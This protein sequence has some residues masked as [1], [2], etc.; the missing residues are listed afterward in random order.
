MMRLP[1]FRY[2]APGTLEEAA[3]IMAGEGPS[4]SLLAGGTDLL[5]KLK[6]G[7]QEPAAL[8]SLSKIG[9]LREMR[10][11]KGLTLG[12]GVSL[13]EIVAVPAIC[14]NY[15][16]LWQA[17]SQVA[18]PQI[19]NVGT[20]GGNLCVD[21]R[22]TYHDQSHDWRK[23]I[24]FCI[25]QD[26][27]TCWASPTS[28]RCWAVSSSD[29]APALTALGAEIR[30]V[31][32]GGE[33]ILPL[34]DFYCDDGAA[35]LTRRPDEILAE[36]ILPPGKG[37][38]STYWKLRRRGAYDFP[39]ASVAAAVATDGDGTVTAARLYLGAIVSG[40]IACRDAESL[41]VGSK[42]TDELIDEASK[43]AGATA[44][45]KENTDAP[46]YWR[47]RMVVPM[48][49]WALKELRGDDMRDQ[50]RRLAGQPTA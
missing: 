24:G 13:G 38:K 3:G 34:E 1:Q 5:P 21:T 15:R 27:E 37:W 31:S 6:R 16:A 44:R 43:L 39:I 29:T 17:A 19:R 12:A 4:A 26:G 20:V 2:F 48:T 42:L 18:T 11:G 8:V 49:T 9:H 28:D 50:R 40:F 36:I 41:L 35:H 10:N 45:P 30:L 14:E 25:K 22:C 32:A 23:A 7:Q 46:A 47:R 33:R